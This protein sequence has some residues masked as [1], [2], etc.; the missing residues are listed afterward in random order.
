[1]ENMLTEKLVENL[2]VVKTGHSSQQD[3]LSTSSKSKTTDE[4]LEAR[5]QCTEFVSKI[6]ENKLTTIQP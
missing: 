3:K 4:I 6:V 2:E 5:E 1:M